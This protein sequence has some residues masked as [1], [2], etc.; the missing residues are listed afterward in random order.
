MARTP[1]GGRERTTQLVQHPA[2]DDGQVD[3]VW[4]NRGS[5]QLTFEKYEHVR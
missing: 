1:P 4:C 3:T 2:S 5:R